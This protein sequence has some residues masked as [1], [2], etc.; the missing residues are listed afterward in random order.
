MRNASILSLVSIVGF[1]QLSACDGAGVPSASGSAGGGGT[2]TTSGAAGSGAAGSGA[3]GTGQQSGVAGSSSQGAAG[4]STGVAGDSG[5]AGATTGV[6]GAGAA[7]ATGTAGAGAAG[8]GAAGAGATGTAGA[9]AAGTGGGT[10]ASG[11]SDGCGKMNTDAPAKWVEHD[12]MVTVAPAYAP[13]FQ[14]RKYFTMMP[15]GYDPMKAYPVT[16]WGPGCGASGAENNQL[17]GSL[18]PDG[19]SA[20]DTFIQVFVLQ[21]GGCFSTGA[22]DS[23]EVPYFDTTLAGVEAGYCV[24]KG[25]VFVAGYS[26]GSWLSHLLG[27]QRGDVLRGIGSASGGILVDH[28]TCTGPLAAIMT[29]DSSDTTNPIISVD[30]K[31]GTAKGS[32]AARDRILTANGCQMTSKDWDPAFPG[33]VIYDG[34]MPNYP[35][36]WC[37]TMGQGHSSGGINSSKG[38]WK[39]WSTLP[40][41]P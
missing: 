13:A 9:G 11:K 38:F 21:N 7:G 35:V 10:H 6:A 8:A 25:Q 33:C 4:S 27:C 28:G 31:T 14:M 26:S 18:G 32:G 39:F 36:V 1:L 34:C 29:G 12:V 37:L 23:P 2:S 22:H 5:A 40:K 20:T 41:L 17:M 30:S 16:M 19:K 24:D 3:A 15:H